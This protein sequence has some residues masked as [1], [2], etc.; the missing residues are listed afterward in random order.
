MNRPGGS[1]RATH[2]SAVQ[3]SRP[4]VRGP[5]Y[6]EVPDSRGS[7]AP[8]HRRPAAARGTR[9]GRHRDAGAPAGVRGVRGE[10]EHRSA[11]PQVVAGRTPSRIPDVSAIAVRGFASEPRVATLDGQEHVVRA[12]GPTF[13]G[14]GSRLVAGRRVSSR[15]PGADG[16]WR[17][18]LDGGAPSLVWRT[19]R[20]LTSFRGRHRANPRGRCRRTAPVEGGLARRLVG[21]TSCGSI[22]AVSRCTA[23]STSMTTGVASSFN[24]FAT[25]TCRR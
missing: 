7:L 10:A 16:M 3:R 24:G 19:D 9:S 23:R 22:R 17:A 8:P 13:T 20:K 1:H 4:M 15:S 25:R 11:L 12:G 21:S 5:A 6:L 2:T 14:G 18:T